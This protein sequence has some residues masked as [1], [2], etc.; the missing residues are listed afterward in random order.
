[1]RLDG[2][3]FR[4]RKDGDY[5]DHDDG[6][7]ALADYFGNTRSGIYDGRFALHRELDFQQCDVAAAGVHLDR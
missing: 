1:M 4:W 6:G 2:D 5:G 7:T 3:Q